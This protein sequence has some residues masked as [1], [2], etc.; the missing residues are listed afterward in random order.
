M[1]GLNS[2]YLT[3]KVTTYHAAGYTFIVKDL[4]I[5]GFR[6]FLHEV[7]LLGVAHM[8]R[9]WG[10]LHIFLNKVEGE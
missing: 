7:L 3:L 6:K 4:A 8:D 5:Y 10:I 1:L 9:V 2:F